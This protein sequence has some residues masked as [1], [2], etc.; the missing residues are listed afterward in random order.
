MIKLN[1]SDI[2]TMMVGST[3]VSKVM[4]GSTETWTSFVDY[5]DRYFTTFGSETLSSDTNVQY[6]VSMGQNVSTSALS[7]IEYSIDNGI[8]WTK[9]NNQD[10]QYVS[11]TTPSVSKTTKVLWRG[12]NKAL[13]SGTTYNDSTNGSYMTTIKCM[14]SSTLMSCSFDAEGNI[15]SLLY[16]SDF[17]NKTTFPTDSVYTFAGLFYKSTIKDCSNLIMPATTMVSD[18]YNDMFRQSQVVIPPVLSAPTVGNTCYKR[19]FHTCTRIIEI[20]M[21]ATTISNTNAFDN[22]LQNGANNSNC[23]LYKNRQAQW[24]NSIVP[25]LWNIELVDV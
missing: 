17:K 9:V 10:N 22:W 21:Y 18:C 8:T 16:G 1:S 6:L 4:V 25:N 13:S 7:Y 11:I 23:T 14:D 24:T 3:P 12:E 15:M 20:R 19:M 2:A 5:K